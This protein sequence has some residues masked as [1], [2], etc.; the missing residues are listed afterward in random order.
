[1]EGGGFEF[2]YLVYPK[3]LFLPDLPVN[4]SPLTAISQKKLRKSVSKL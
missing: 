3:A 1:M 2:K 4:F